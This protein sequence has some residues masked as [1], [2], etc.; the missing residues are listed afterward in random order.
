MSDDNQA[1]KDYA[2]ASFEN[3]AQHYA[4]LEFFKTSAKHV[5]ELIQQPKPKLANTKFS[6]LDVAC[7]TG[8]VVLACAERFP[9]ANITG[10]DISEDMLSYARQQS[11]KMNCRNV[12][13]HLQDMVDLSGFAINQNFDVITCSYG[14]FFLEEPQ[15]T[16][17]QLYEFLKPQ[18][19]II[20]T[21]F[22]PK[23]FSPANEI[24][25]DLLKQHHSPS[26]MAFEEN[27]WKNLKTINNI[28]RLLE[29]AN[30]QVEPCT[31]I[32]TKKIRYNLSLDEWWE[33]INNT[34]YKGMLLELDKN[35]LKIVK[36]G[37]YAAM[38][39]HLNN[40]SVELIADS[41]FVSIYKN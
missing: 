22:L 17:A 35:Q 13:F 31:N 29:L 28:N 23:A 41:Y 15:C 26:A 1:A 25:L 18:G 37:F 4:T 11:E 10:I 5:A 20:F 24:L 39:N 30:L 36:H 40:N 32:E 3:A 8:N 6:I 34:G 27:S 7:G 19:C 9:Q 14:L 21:S 38:Q 16:L 12:Q 2:K 33:L